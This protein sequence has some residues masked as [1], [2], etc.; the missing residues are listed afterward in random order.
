MN[1]KQDI[2]EE[3]YIPKE[4][5]MPVRTGR[6]KLR[7]PREGDGQALYEAKLETWDM[8]SKWLPWAD[9]MSTP[10]D[11]EFMVIEANKKF[12]E[13]KDLMMFGFDADTG[14]LLLSTGLHR[15]NWMTRR[16]E[17]G[18]WV[19]KSAQNK[20]YA[21]EALNALTRYAFDVLGASVVITEIQ[22]GNDS[23]LN[24]MKKL[25]FEYDGVFQKVFK[26]TQKDFHLF[27]T[28]SID[29][30]PRLSVKWGE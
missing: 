13:R 8:I 10:E 22:E 6:L 24:M 4:F 11:D 3:D 25:G 16:F 7:P 1:M 2:P 29:N 14:K 30:L 15:F 19:R 5:P 27:F 17:I 20:G 9:G 21:A 28:T 18:V 23:S 26:G 12:E